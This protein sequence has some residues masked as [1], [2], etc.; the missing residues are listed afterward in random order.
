MRTRRAV[1][2]GLWVSLALPFPLALTVGAI[3]AVAQ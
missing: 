2:I 1:Q 3:P